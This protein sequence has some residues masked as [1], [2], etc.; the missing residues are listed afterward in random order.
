VVRR[1]IGSVARPEPVRWQFL[2]FPGGRA[3]CQYTRQPPSGLPACLFAGSA[4][5]VNAPVV[6]N[7]FDELTGKLKPGQTISIRDDAGRRIDGKLTEVS[8][9]PIRVLSGGVQ[10]TLTQEHVLSTVCRC[11]TEAE[12]SSWLRSFQSRKPA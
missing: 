12:R 2:A 8:A 7:S 11:P 4:R 9:S 5:I 3:Q 10:Q 6:A 1:K